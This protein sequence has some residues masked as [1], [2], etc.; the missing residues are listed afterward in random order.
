MKREIQEAS[1]ATNAWHSNI[2]VLNKEQNEAKQD[3]MNP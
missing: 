2:S 3:L 1:D